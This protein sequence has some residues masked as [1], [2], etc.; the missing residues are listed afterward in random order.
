MRVALLCQNVEMTELVV[1]KV[2]RK[3]KERIILHEIS[4]SME[5]GE[6]IGLMGETGSG[7]TTLLKM[8]AGL[9]QPSSGTI[10]FQSKRVK[11]PDE[12]LLPGHPQIEIGRA[13]V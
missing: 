5:K 4:F 11:G 13:H 8:I 7:K 2:L 6:K 10:E 9:L 3:E 12:V 1:D